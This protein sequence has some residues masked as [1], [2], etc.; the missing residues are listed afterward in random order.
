M[1]VLA[2]AFGFAPLAPLH[3]LAAMAAG[4]AMLIPFQLAKRW[5]GGRSR[6]M[7]DA[8]GG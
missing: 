3:W 2:Q 1:P 5:L 6:S 8:A 7:V 4:L